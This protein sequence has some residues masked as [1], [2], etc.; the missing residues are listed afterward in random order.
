[1]TQEE[2]LSKILQRLPSLEKAS[3][4]VKDYLTMRLKS[5]ED[6]LP[7]AK[8]LK[9]ELGFD[10]LEIVTATD[11]LGPVKPEG[12]ICNPNPNVLLP[13]GATPQAMPGA[14]PGVSYRPF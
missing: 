13:E 9:E 6:L 11:W 3:A 14:T 5:S 1:M 7:T 4:P 10:Y 12:Y 8:A 2:L